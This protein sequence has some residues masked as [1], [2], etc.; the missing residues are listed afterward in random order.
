[1][2]GGMKY[3]KL[4][5]KK[6][7]GRKSE[8]QTKR[9]AQRKSNQIPTRCGHRGITTSRIKLEALSDEKLV[10]KSQRKDEI[11]F[12]VL[13]ERHS[14]YILSSA[15][16]ASSFEVEEVLQ[17]TYIKCWQ[18]IS[19]FKFKSSFKTWIFRVL[20]NNYYDVARKE[21]KRKEREVYFSDLIKDEDDEKK[22]L[23]FIQ[24]NVILYSSEGLPGSNLEREEER[25]H[26]NKILKKVKNRLSPVQTEIIELVLEQEMTYQEAAKEIKCSVGTVMSRL[27]YA[28]KKA[29]KVIKENH[30]KI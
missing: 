20:R 21:G 19:T 28:R 30:E 3:A 23:D 18:R 17:R 11:A 14:G 9:K 15:L 8:K 25:D 2:I 7:T 26:L 24:G 4:M 1:M 22:S 16:K 12:E 13:M 27:F 5:E 10:R 29:R 6:T